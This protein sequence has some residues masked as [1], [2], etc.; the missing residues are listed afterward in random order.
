MI[1]V[2]RFNKRIGILDWVEEENELG[3]TINK[4]KS[5]REVWAEIH[6]LKG[7]E[8]I[9]GQMLEAET[10]YKITCRYFGEINEDMLI[11]YGNLQLMIISICDVDMG[12]K[13]Y[14]IMCKK[15]K[16]RQKEIL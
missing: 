12:H 11:S 8:Y 13:F 7:R 1:N 15:N 5:V 3:Q 6:P 10:T 2:G 14:E 9:E 16:K 4:L